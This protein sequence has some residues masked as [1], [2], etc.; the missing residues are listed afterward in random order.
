[1]YCR[2]CGHKN[3]PEDAYCES[4]GKPTA[5]SSE[6][7]TRNKT[8]RPKRMVLVFVVVIVIAAIAAWFFINNMGG[9]IG[10]SMGGPSEA[11]IASARYPDGTKPSDITILQKAKC[12]LSDNLR[13]KGYKE[14]WIV[15]YTNDNLPAYMR[16][17]INTW[18][19]G[20]LG[21]DG[22]RWVILYGDVSG[23]PNI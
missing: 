4:C 13:A 11:D 23:C 14:K 18:Y 17:D 9:S 8:S 21:Y 16:G 3:E 7:S 22:Y 6:V 20:I 15:K 12:N 1:M 5:A 19:D 2:Y 10:G